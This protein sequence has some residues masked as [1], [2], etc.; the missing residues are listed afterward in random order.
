[1]TRK[2]PVFAAAAVTALLA[3]VPA[4]AQQGQATGPLSARVGHYDPTG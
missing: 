2:S 4:L 1:M 3:A